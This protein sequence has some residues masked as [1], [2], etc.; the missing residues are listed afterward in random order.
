[1]ETET[2][3]SINGT[4]KMDI[5]LDNANFT[6]TR[7]VRDVSDLKLDPLNQRISYKIKLKGIVATDKELDSMLWGMDSVKELYGSI[8]QNGGLIDDPI[9]RK[10]NIVVE[11]NCRTVALRQLHKKYPKDPRFSKLYVQVLPENVT[12]EQITILI[13]ELHIAGKIQWKAYEQAEYVWKMNKLYGKSYDFLANHL[14][15]SR[16]KLAQKISA[17]HET[18]EY[19]QRTGDS[20]GINRY[21][22]FEE[23]MKKGELR[24]RREQESG[25][26]QTFGSWI[27]EKKILESKD[28][29]VLPEILSIPEAYKK[30]I[31]SGIEEA[32][33][34]IYS[35]NPSLVSNLYNAV[36]VAVNQLETISLQEIQALKNKPEEKVDKIKRLKAAIDNLES[37][38]GYKL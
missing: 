2:K 26:M 34:V 23:F 13:G 35:K 7:E 32:R 11:G 6:L 16:S 4:Q 24:E 30:F 12:D 20:A 36:D 33:K 38:L 10:D 15:W 28:V 1:M 18:K 37:F 5:R 19:L 17:Y 31:E 29:R 3:T 27:H 25:F 22:F 8:Y 9:I 21:S 14:R